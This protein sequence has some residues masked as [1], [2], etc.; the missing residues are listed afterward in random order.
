M[1][2]PPIKKL[3]SQPG[4]RNLIMNAAAGCAESLGELPAGVGVSEVAEVS[5]DPVRSALRFCLSDEV[6][7]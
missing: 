3:R 6:R 2:T 5:I 4:Q 1:V 7:N